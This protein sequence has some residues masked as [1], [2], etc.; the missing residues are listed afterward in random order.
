MSH[1]RES[2]KGM[3]NL[4]DE[5]SDASSQMLIV[6]PTSALGTTFKRLGNDAWSTSFMTTPSSVNHVLRNRQ[7]HY[8]SLLCAPV[9]N[10]RPRP[11]SRT[12]PRYSADTMQKS[13]SSGPF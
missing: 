11:T 10:P 3:V 12:F 7:F 2:P 1:P 5:V 4:N 13:M 8:R 9:D 6:T